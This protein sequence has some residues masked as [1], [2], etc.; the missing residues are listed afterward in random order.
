[1]KYLKNVT[2][3]KLDRDKCI[4][5]GMCMTVCPHAVF[6]LR[7][8]KADITDRDACMECGACAGNCPAD[9]IAVEAG[10]GC[11]T[12]FIVGA[13]TGTEPTCDCAKGSKS[14]C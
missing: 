12:A 4:G 1:M 9:A 13:I 5:C 11:A 14:R 8:K 3:L 6:V 7:E 2:T 10:V